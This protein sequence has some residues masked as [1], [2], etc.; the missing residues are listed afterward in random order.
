MKLRLSTFEYVCEP[1]GHRF[2]APGGVVGEAG[3]LV[4]RS[5]VPGSLAAVT[6]DDPVADELSAVIDDVLGE[7]PVSEGDR[8]TI[9]RRLVGA[10]CDPDDDGSAFEVERPPTCPVGGE[11][12]VQD[13]Q[14]LEPPD[15]RT[16]DVPSVTHRRWDAMDPEE[17]RDLV[18]DRLR[19]D[20]FLA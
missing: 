15:V 8:G 11:T 6:A 13:W 17:R 18:R 19:A 12:R 10:V 3:V 5:A 9:F 4:L 7:T 14:E 16:I 1:A 2:R 20:R